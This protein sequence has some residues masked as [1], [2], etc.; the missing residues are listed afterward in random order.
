VP[1]RGADASDSV[2]AMTDGTTIEADPHH[3]RPA[4][5]PLTL[6]A[7]VALVV[8]GYIG[9][10]F[11]TDLVNER[12][13]V[14]IALH[15]RVRHLLL[16]AGGDITWW[17]YGLVGGLR[18]AL[19]YA[20]CHLIGRA[21]GSDVLVWFGRYLGVTGAQIQNILQMFHKAEWFVLP[22]FVGSNVVAAIT[23]ISRTPLPRLVGL[24][25]LGIV[26]RLVLYWL[27]ARVFFESQVDSVLDF[28]AT[29]QRPALIA[30]IALT[31]GAIGLNLYRG[32]KFEL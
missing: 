22:F 5:A 7:W 20:V 2:G 27:L 15:A 4:W 24:V 6:I 21:Y 29:Y 28:L 17:E 32:R 12:P 23:G 9:T 19:A 13:V 30:M 1:G 16:A 11:S 10:A 8:A 14:L 3:E 25:T 26:G 18:L 31:V